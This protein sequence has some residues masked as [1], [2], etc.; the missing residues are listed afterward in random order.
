MS[1]KTICLNCGKPM[2]YCECKMTWDK[3]MANG[4]P[5]EDYLKDTDWSQVKIT[6]SVYNPDANVAPVTEFEYFQQIGNE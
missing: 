2:Q 1:N 5:L 3:L 6:T 4:T